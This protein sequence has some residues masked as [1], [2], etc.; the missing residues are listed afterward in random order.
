MTPVHGVVD[1]GRR[2]VYSGLVL[3]DLTITFRVERSFTDRPNGS[4]SIEHQ[5]S[6]VKR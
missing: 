4:N 5:L 2:S 3:F 6:V 1:L